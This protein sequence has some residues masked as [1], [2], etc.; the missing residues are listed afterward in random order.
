MI[1]ELGLLGLAMCLWIAARKQAGLVARPA[2]GWFGAML[3]LAAVMGAWLIHTVQ[4]HKTDTMG[5]DAPTWKTWWMALPRVF[6]SYVLG[7]WIGR[8]YKDGARTPGLPWWLA[9]ALPVL[10]IAMVP[11]LPLSPAHG[12]LVFVMLFLPLV[13]WLVAMSHP[14]QAMKAPMEWLGNFSL[15]LYCVHLTV[16]VWMSEVL[17]LA[18]WV[19][20]AAVAAAMAQRPRP[21]LRRCPARR[22]LHRIPARSAPDPR[23][24][25]GRP[26][27]LDT[28]GGAARPGAAQRW[29]L[30]V[31]WGGTNHDERQ[32]AQVALFAGLDRGGGRRGRLSPERAAGR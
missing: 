4:L 10:G 13:M 29:P 3:V 5:V 8:K 2:T 22:L 15:P 23:P 26:R 14:P 11:Q 25:P 21:R 31:R 9:M 16:L 18:T 12:D 24:E 28:A 27:R 30:S 1:V 20:F 17:G 19:R 7:V 32:P 6:F